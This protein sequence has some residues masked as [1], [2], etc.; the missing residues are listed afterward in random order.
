MTRDALESTDPWKSIPKDPDQHGYLNGIVTAR[1]HSMKG[2]PVSRC[3]RS[4]FDHITDQALEGGSGRIGGLQMVALVGT[5]STE[6]LGQ[7]RSPS[8]HGMSLTLEDQGSRPFGRGH[9]GTIAGEGRRVRLSGNTA[10]SSHGLGNGVRKRGIGGH[11]HRGID[12]T[13]TDERSGHPEDLGTGSRGRIEGKHGA[14][15]T[16][17]QGNNGGHGIP[18]PAAHGI[19]GKPSSLRGGKIPLHGDNPAKRAPADATEGRAS[20]PGSLTP[21]TIPFGSQSGRSPSLFSNAQ[22]QKLMTAQ[23]GEISRCESYR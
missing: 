22:G 1:S 18:A 21:Q 9:S 17:S 20:F 8:R 11:A 19:R 5:C 7:E 6:P 16:M 23:D 2:N 10:I 15:E 4:L 12:N 3:I 14:A 13:T